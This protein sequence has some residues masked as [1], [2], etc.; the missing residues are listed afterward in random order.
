MPRQNLWKPFIVVASYVFYGYASWTFCLLL[1]AVTLGNQA[2]AVL[3]ARTA[4]ERARAW[5][6]GAAVAFDLGML[7]VFKSYAFFV[8]NVDRALGPF[9]MPLPLL[10]I[11]LPVGV[12]FFTFQ[13]ISYTV[14]VKR[15]L[16]EPASTIDV[17]VY[18]SFFPHLVAGPIVRA[19]EFIP[20]LASA[21]DP[22]HVAVGAGLGLVGM[23]LVKKVMIADYLGRTIVDPAFGVPQAYHG[24]DL[25]FAAY[26]YAAQIYCDFSGYTDIAI[27]LALLMGFVFP[28]NFRSPYRATG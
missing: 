2:A 7:G 10:T 4:S 11:A 28:Q 14:D 16:V 13:A 12:S 15:R 17:A 8:E 1:A 24:P 26:S 5:I 3:I 25:L 18:L 6:L 9:S 22:E 19:R 27:G 20:Q 23:G 21:R